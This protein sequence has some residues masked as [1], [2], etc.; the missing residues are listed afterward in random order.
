MEGI[1]TET[2][3]GVYEAAIAYGDILEAAD[4]AALFK[5]AAKEICA[6]HGVMASFMAKWNAELPGCSGHVHQSL[7]TLDGERN[8]FADPRGERGMSKA[9][10]HFLA[11]QLTLMPELTALI[12][13]T[14][15]SYKRYVPGVWAPLNATWGYENRTCALRVIGAPSPGEPRGSGENKA[16]RIEHRQPA[17]DMNAH[18]VMA[19]LLAAGLYGIERKLEPQAASAADA[20][21][22]GAASL[23]RCLEEAVERL[24]KSTV[25][26]ELLGDT[27]VDHYIRT[28]DWEVRQYQRAVTDWELARYFEII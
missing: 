27:F 1:H 3:P 19:A 25:A 6:R 12:S 4:R 16:M 21:H 28:R 15:N 10:R 22:S 14:V 11:G 13:P 2:G 18:I 17:A 9:M 26:R 20:T 8:C 23:P 5:T 7:W 24:S